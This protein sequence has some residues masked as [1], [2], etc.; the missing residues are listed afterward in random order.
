MYRVYRYRLGHCASVLIEHAIRAYDTTF[1]LMVGEQCTSRI[2]IKYF[3]IYPQFVV[4]IYIYLVYYMTF[5]I[6][7]I[8]P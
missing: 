7:A 2:Y 3:H 8:I 6:Y 1:D 4:I 5:I